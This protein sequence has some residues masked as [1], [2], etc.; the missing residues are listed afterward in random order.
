MHACN[1]HVIICNIELYI[2]C[3]TPCVFK[4]PRSYRELACQ[5]LS[6]NICLALTAQGL[7]QRG[8]V[9]S[10]KL[11]VKVA[12]KVHVHRR[13][14]GQGKCAWSYAQVVPTYASSLHI[15]HL[16]LGK[17]CGTVVELC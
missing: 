16:V 4:G 15:S 5:A 9:T 6:Q 11:T 1:V 14:Q 12:F 3:V 8:N 2:I 10:L 17:L 7:I 13:D